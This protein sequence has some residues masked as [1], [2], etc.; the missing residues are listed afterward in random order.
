MLESPDKYTLDSEPVLEEVSPEAGTS[1]RKDHAFSAHS[2]TEPH[3]V[4]KAE[5]NDIVQDLNLPR[6]KAWLLGSWLQQWN[7]LEKGV[8][9][10]FYRKRQLN[11]AKYFLMDGD[12]VYCND[13]CGLM[14]ELKFQG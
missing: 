6:T 10:S 7:L 4:T 14:E 13:I 5:L 12:L 3:S 9:A 8:R 2:S 1:T 11:T